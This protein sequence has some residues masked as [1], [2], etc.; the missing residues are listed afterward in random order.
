MTGIIEYVAVSIDKGGHGDPDAKDLA[1]MRRDLAKYWGGTKDLIRIGRAYPR[2]SF[3]I[4]YLGIDR[5]KNLFY[6]VDT[7]G[8][9]R[10]FDPATGRLGKAIPLPTRERKLIWDEETW[11]LKEGLSHTRSITRRP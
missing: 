8:V 9:C 10:Q 7:E 6:W 11:E 1:Q 2:N 5:P 4:G 3:R